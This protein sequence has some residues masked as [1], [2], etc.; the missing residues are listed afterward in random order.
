MLRVVRLEGRAPVMYWDGDWSGWNWFAMGFS[1]L[2]FWGLV[3]VVI[4]LAVR[5]VSS[6]RPAS[7]P[8]QPPSAEDALRRRY[9][10]GQIDDE[11]FT[12]RLRVLRG[13]GL[14]RT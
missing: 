2:V 4:W 9:A 8:A 6:T 11:E 12:R 5:A 3:A 13:E 7:P 14:T 1:M 10:D